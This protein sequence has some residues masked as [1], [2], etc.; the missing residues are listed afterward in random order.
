MS[1][2][3]VIVETVVYGVVFFLSFFFVLCRNELRQRGIGLPFVCQSVRL[4]IHS[5]WNVAIS[6]LTIV[7]PHSVY[8][9]VNGSRQAYF[10]LAGS[11]RKKWVN[12]GR[13][14]HIYIPT[15]LKKSFFSWLVGGE[16]RKK[17][18]EGCFF[19]CRRQCLHVGGLVDHKI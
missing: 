10:C 8:F 14:K 13:F 5:P 9:T 6:C 1:V 15:V 3:A 18:L 17:K 19:S 12:Y 16:N 2:K 4:F 11:C 7:R